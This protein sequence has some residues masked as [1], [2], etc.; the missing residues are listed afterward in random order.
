[1]SWQ[2]DILSCVSFPLTDLIDMVEL[3]PNDADLVLR[4]RLVWLQR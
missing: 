3:P 2:D 1:M 4:H